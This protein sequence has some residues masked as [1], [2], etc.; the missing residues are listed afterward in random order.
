M[1]ESE[2]VGWH[3]R[4][5]GHDFEQTLGVGDGQRSLACCSPWGHKELD[6]N[7]RLNNDIAVLTSNLS[8]LEMCTSHISLFPPLPLFSPDVSAMAPWFCQLLHTFLSLQVGATPEAC[9]SPVSG[10]SA[11]LSPHVLVNW[12]L[13]LMQIIALPLDLFLHWWPCLLSH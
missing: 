6:T 12:S 4:L 1:T 7:E 11:C 3:H 10:P 5:N 9:L 8:S 2:I 13:W